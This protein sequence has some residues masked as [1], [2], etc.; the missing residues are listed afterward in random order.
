MSD[1]P[2]KG[3]G[4]GLSAL[5]GEEAEA[6]SDRDRGRATHTVPIEQISPSQLQPRRRFDDAEMASLVDSVRSKGILQPIL[7]RRDTLHADAFR[8][9]DVIMTPS[10]P[11]TG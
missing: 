6:S 4:R 8:D 3:L 2:R 1:E 5:L 11:I 9:H 10:A 7:V